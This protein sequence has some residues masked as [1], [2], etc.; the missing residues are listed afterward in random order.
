[1]SVME[2]CYQRTKPLFPYYEFLSEFQLNHQYPSKHE[3]NHEW[4]VA[5]VDVQEFHDL[6]EYFPDKQF[7]PE[8]VAQSNPL[9]YFAVIVPE[10][11]YRHFAD[12]LPKRWSHSNA[13]A[14]QTSVDPA[15]LESKY[16]LL[17]QDSDN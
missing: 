15:M 3:Y 13:I 14:F 5:L 6:P 1:M 10:L 12:E 16:F 4:F 17:F 9:P 7:D 11:S 8:K 2:C